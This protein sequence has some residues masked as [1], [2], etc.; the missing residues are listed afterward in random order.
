MHGAGVRGISERLVT[1]VEG[2]GG[3]V[4]WCAVLDEG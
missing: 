2:A 1:D 4:V 3:C